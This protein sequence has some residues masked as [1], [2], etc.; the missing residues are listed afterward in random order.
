ALFDLTEFKLNRRGTT[1]NQHSHTQTVFLVVN[2]FN[3][4]GKIVER[5]IDNTNHLAWL[6]NDLVTRFV[7]T[8]FQTLQNAVCFTLGNRSRLVSLATDKTKNSRCLFYKVPGIVVQFHFD[9][10]VTREE[11]T[12]AF[13]LLSGAHFK[14]FFGRDN[15]FTKEMFHA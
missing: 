9:Q 8:F 11:F 14:N 7:L 3:S 2:F 5:T 1:K 6:V 12:L 4:T 13:A 15:H 10:N